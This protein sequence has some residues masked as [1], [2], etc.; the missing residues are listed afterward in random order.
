MLKKKQLQGTVTPD[1]WAAAT[2]NREQLPF[3][4]DY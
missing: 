1:R 2:T 3:S 4:P